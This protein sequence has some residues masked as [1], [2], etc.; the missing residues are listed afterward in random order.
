MNPEDQALTGTYVK[1]M[2]LEAAIIA[3]LWLMGRLFS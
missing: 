1:V 3:A 2:L